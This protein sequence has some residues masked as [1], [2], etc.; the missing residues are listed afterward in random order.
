MLSWGTDEAAVVA[1]KG[2][3][4]FV[5]AS[6]VLYIHWV[7]GRSLH[8]PAQ[9][10]PCGCNASRLCGCV[11]VWLCGYVRL[12]GCVAVCAS[13]H[14]RVGLNSSTFWLRLQ[15]EDKSIFD[16]ARQLFHAARC[17]LT[18][19]SSAIEHT[20]HGTSSCA[21]H[22]ARSPHPCD[23]IAATPSG[24]VVATSVVDGSAGSSVDDGSVVPASAASTSDPRSRAPSSTRRDGRGCFVFVYT[25]RCRGMGKALRDAAALSGMYMRT[26]HRSSLLTAEQ[27]A[28]GLFYSTRIVVASPWEEA[29]EGKG[30][31]R[32]VGW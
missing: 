25:P 30:R 4:D 15:G 20:A 28:T 8:V 6:E 13:V 18:P 3:F 32:S 11:A 16:S 23:V 31:T 2:H 1:A 10:H 21:P 12:C 9:S 17:L 7:R 26:V 22:S 24:G 27:V 5:I 19:P 14:A 29:A